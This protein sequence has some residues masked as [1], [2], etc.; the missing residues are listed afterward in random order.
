MEDNANK[1]RSPFWIL[2]WTGLALLVVSTVVDHDADY[3]LGTGLS[4]AF[5]AANIGLAVWVA[6]ALSR[7]CRWAKFAYV[8]VAVL[9]GLLFGLGCY[10]L[11]SDNQAIYLMDVASLFAIPAVCS[12]LLLFSKPLRGEFAGRVM[13]K[14]VLYIAAWLA[15]SVG[16][17]GLC[18]LNYFDGSYLPRCLEAA[19]AGSRS[20]AHDLMTELFIVQVARMEDEKA[21]YGEPKVRAYEDAGVA[22]YEYVNGRRPSE[23]VDDDRKKLNDEIWTNLVKNYRGEVDVDAVGEAIDRFI[24]SV[25]ADAGRFDR[26]LRTLTAED[27]RFATELEKLRNPQRPRFRWNAPR[28]NGYPSW[29]PRNW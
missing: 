1:P 26:I 21:H 16:F 15:V 17:S 11:A 22:V 23:A 5:S 13:P 4:T 25:L 20:A 27:R 9:N 10:E 6:V 7:R 19:R 24:Q 12:A 3:V 8:A 28:G 29:S 2:L 14:F 18:A